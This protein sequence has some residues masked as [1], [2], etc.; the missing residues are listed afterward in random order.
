M[1]NIGSILRQARKNRELTLEEVAH[2]TRIKAEFIDAIEKMQWDNL[3][4]YPV[5]AG[6]IKNLANFYDFDRTNLI[7]LL[8]RDYPPKAIPVNPKP[9]LED[10]RFVW[11]PRYAFFAGIA[12]LV[13]GVATYLGYQYYRFLQPPQLEVISPTEGQTVFQSRLVVTGNVSADASVRVNNQPALV[14]QDG[15]FQAEIFLNED[16]NHLE[17]KAADRN[18]KE[19][20]VIRNIQVELDD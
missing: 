16:T 7:A 15:K 9:D 11:K 1:K 17:I 18:G 19:T 2:K 3:P 12:L 10:K 6:F 4:E 5:T 13:L 14:E 8:R 20:V